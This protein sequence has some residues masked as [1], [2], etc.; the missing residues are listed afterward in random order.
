M[1]ALRTALVLALVTALVTASAASAQ[2]ERWREVLSGENA[3]MVFGPNGGYA[4]ENYLKRFKS[5]SGQEVWATQN[6]VLAELIRRTTP[7]GKVRLAAF[8]LDEQDVVNACFEVAKSKNVEVKLW[9]KGPPGLDYMVAGHEALA[10]RANQYLRERAAQNKQAE[11][12]D[13]QVMIGTAAKMAAFGKVN[14]MHEKFGI[15]DL[16]ATHAA[17]RNIGFLGTSNIGASSDRSHNESRLFFHGNAHAAQRLWGEFERLWRN[18]GD[19]RTFKD[20]DPSK[21]VNLTPEGEPRIRVGNGFADE[22]ASDGLSFRFTYERDGNNGPFHSITKDYVAAI[23]E[24]TQLPAGSVVYCAQFGFQISQ[25]TE[26]FVRAAKAAPQVEFKIMVHMAE[27]ETSDVRRLVDARLPNLKVGAKWDSNKL[28]LES[29]ARPQIPDVN[30]PGPP[31]LHH[32]TLVLGDRLLVTGSFN[33]FGDAD[34]QGEQIVIIRNNVAPTFSRVLADTRAEFEALWRSQVILDAAKIDG[35]D[36]LMETIEELSGKDGFLEALNAVGQDGKTAEQVRASLGQGAPSLEV[37][38]GWLDTLARFGFLKADQGG[39]YSKVDPDLAAHAPKDGVRARAL[40]NGPAPV[41]VDPVTPVDPVDPPPPVDPTPTEGPLTGKILLEGAAVRLVAG[42]TTWKVRGTSAL[43]ATL[44]QLSGREV[45]LVGTQTPATSE[46]AAT[47]LVAP[48]RGQV[49]ASV[50]SGQGGVR[51][52]VNGGAP[53]AV[54]GPAAGVLSRAIG[55]D[56]TIDGY[57]YADGVVALAVE[58]TVTRRGPL[59]RT[60]WGALLVNIPKNEKVWVSK[61]HTSGELA[62]AA[63]D[64]QTGWFQTSRLAFGTQT[65]GLVNSIPGQ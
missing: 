53:I 55:R 56:V 59:T 8:R 61:I 32:K 44:R 36:G 65:A 47:R 46:L 25:I 16:T 22:K 29:G 27:A 23:G 54:S 28:I 14:D 31:L 34:A 57:A 10:E 48:T 38:K 3:T 42:A 1:R 11:W 39:R 49:R 4:K 20:G 64:G 2:D 15:V 35:P 50:I 45:T 26:A 51:I 18:L 52:K 30:N 19:C 24:A 21:G 12:G 33:F 60:A 58:A 6:G 9:L 62:N 13:F 63:W 41:V 37:V 17:N 5:A 40:T 43:F 7:G